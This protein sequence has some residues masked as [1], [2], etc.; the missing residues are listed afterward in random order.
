MQDH[1]IRV[2][3]EDGQL[4]AAAA[5]TTQLVREICHRQQADLTARVALGRL[6]TGAALMGCLLKGNQRLALM[7][8]GNGP[9]GRLMVET[10]A[11]GSIRGKVQNSQTGLPPSGDRFDVAGAVRRAGFLHVIKDLGLKEPYR[12]M[13]QL[14]T[15]E[16]GE[17]LAWYLTHS[18]QVPSCVA[19]GVEL[20]SQ[21]EIAAAGGFLVQALPPGDQVQLAQLEESLGRLP[22]TTSQLRRGLGPAQ[23]LE[24]VLSNQSFSRQQRTALTFNCPCNRRQIGDMLAGLGNVELTAM[25]EE[26]DG[27]E[28]ACDYCR[29]TYRF[30][31]TELDALRS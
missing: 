17:D 19:V 7:I 8:E 9:L 5:D 24:N 30:S 4:R 21:G 23:I 2:V 13:V 22:P 28:V 11:A 26:Q 1:L 31:R 20:D 15:S 10:D 3:T 6:L 14:Q 12:S 16:I 27:A 18:E 29:E 25:I